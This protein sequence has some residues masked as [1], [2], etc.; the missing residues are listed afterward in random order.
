MFDVAQPPL[1]RDPLGLIVEST[2]PWGKFTQFVSNETVT[3][4]TLTVLPGQR[5][6]LQRHAGRSEMWHVLEGTGLEATVG[7]DTSSLALGDY[8]WIPT[9]AIHRLANPGT[10]RGVVLEIA[11]GH[12]DEE[13]I[14]RLQDDYDRT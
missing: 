13:D 5:L 4:K 10:D 8:V 6:S 9:G 11:F 2:R 3:V 7:S 14:E 12:F 1:T